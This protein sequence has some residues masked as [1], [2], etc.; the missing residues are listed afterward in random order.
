MPLNAIKG[1]L[2]LLN[3]GFW[4]LLVFS[5]VLVQSRDLIDI[6]KKLYMLHELI[7]FYFSWAF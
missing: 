6:E 3:N 7:A 5:I 4:L 1:F 2:I